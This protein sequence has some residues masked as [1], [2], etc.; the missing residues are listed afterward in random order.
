MGAGSRARTAIKQFFRSCQHPTLCRETQAGSAW[1]APNGF[2]FVIEVKKS[3][4]PLF[5]MQFVKQLRT[6]NTHARGGG[7]A[8]SDDE[9]GVVTGSASSTNSIIR[10]LEE[11]PIVLAS[12]NHSDPV[13]VI[14]KFSSVAIASMAT[15]EEWC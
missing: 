13:A 4:R 7:H 1:S 14:R 15:A 12:M 6:P 3:G 8:D 10:N 2:V 5:V 9:Y 11:L